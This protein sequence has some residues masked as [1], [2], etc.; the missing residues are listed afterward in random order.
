MIVK[1]DEGSQQTREGYSGKFFITSG[2]LGGVF[3]AGSLVC[4]VPH[5]LD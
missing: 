2:W 5:V 4:I 3:R 1:D